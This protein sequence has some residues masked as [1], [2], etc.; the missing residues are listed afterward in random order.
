M[1]LT[2]YLINNR[3]LIAFLPLQQELKFTSDKNYLF[4]LSY[5]KV[6][7]IIGDRGSE[8]LQGQI[9]CDLREVKANQMQQGALCNLKGRILAL[10]D[11][12]DW[13]GLH[14]IL[15]QDL[16]SDTQASLNKT[17]LFSQVKL[18][19]ST[20]YQLLGF[21]LNQ[22]NDTIPFNAKLPLEKHGVIQGDNYCCYHLTHN[23]YIFI[24]TTPSIQNEID[25]FMPNQWR[26]SLAWHALQLQTHQVEIYPLTRGL[27]LPHRL[28]LQHSGH[29]SFNKG[30]YKGQEIIARTHYRAKLKHELKLF[31][32]QTNK[33][34][35]SGLRL[36]NSDGKVEIGELIDFCPTDNGQY[37]IAVSAF[38]DHAKQVLIE[39]HETE[40]TL[41]KM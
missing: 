31:K 2:P 30:C 38:F 8:F 27:F 26:G 22:P 20:G 21:Q 32:I 6:L 29:L 37:M 34:L 13:H 16:M 7:N 12:I 28:G 14:L 39:G 3:E 40:L 4:N 19:P 1:S 17:A 11:V 33:K 24:V 35:Q 25:I 5:L 15:P 41:H 36:F 18:E 9:T 23:L 10:F